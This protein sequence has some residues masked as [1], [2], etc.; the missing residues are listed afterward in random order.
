MKKTPP[1]IQLRRNAGTPE[2]LPPSPPP[3][4]LP[5]TSP[6]GNL[7]VQPNFLEDLNRTL[8]RKS[9]TRHGSLTSSRVSAQLEPVATMDDMV[10]PPPPPELLLEQKQG[11]YASSNISGYATLRR[12]PPPAPP[13]RDQSTKLT[14]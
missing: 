10:L 13:K 6:K 11:N 4:Q 8:K 1:P 3:Q 12:G 5:P 9:V 2:P 7:T 14:G